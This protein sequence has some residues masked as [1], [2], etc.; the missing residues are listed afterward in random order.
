[1]HLQGLNMSLI[2]SGPAYAL[3]QN[4]QG[5]AEGTHESRGGEMWQEMEQRQGIGRKQWS[6]STADAPCSHTHSGMLAHH[7]R[8]LWKPSP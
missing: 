7:P 5:K 2:R 1:M 4:A 6:G 8:S 3:L